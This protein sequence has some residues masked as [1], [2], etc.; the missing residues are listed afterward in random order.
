MFSPGQL[1]LE[2]QHSELQELEQSWN[3]KDS[4]I[5]Q[6]MMT[7]DQEVKARSSEE[8]LQGPDYAETTDTDG[9]SG[10]DD[11]EFEAEQLKE[12]EQV[13]ENYEIDS[14]AGYA[15]SNEEGQNEIVSPSGKEKNAGTSNKQMKDENK[16]SQEDIEFFSLRMAV[17]KRQLN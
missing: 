11:S 16:L 15:Q 2:H 14:S 12:V 8:A 9:T 6:K 5:E 10:S 3:Y 17:L 13:T 4:V 1:L 7:T